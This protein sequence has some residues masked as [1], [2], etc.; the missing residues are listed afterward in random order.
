[1]WTDAINKE[2]DGLRSQKIWKLMTLKEL[3]QEGHVN[4]TR[5]P[6]CRSGGAGSGWPSWLQLMWGGQTRQRGHTAIA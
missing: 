6:H 5:R 4:S 1:M 3:V 2:L